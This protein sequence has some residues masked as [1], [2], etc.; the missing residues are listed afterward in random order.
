MQQQRTLVYTL[1]HKNAQLKN[2]TAYPPAAHP[3]Q[4]PA[5]IPRCPPRSTAYRRKKRPETH[6]QSLLSPDQL[7]EYRVRYL[8]LPPGPHQ[9]DK[10]DDLEKRDEREKQQHSIPHVDDSVG[11]TPGSPISAATALHAGISTPVANPGTPSASIGTPTASPATLEARLKYQL[12]DLSHLHWKRRQKRLAEIAREQEML[13]NGEVPEVS[14]IVVEETKPKGEKK[15][16]EKEKEA[17]KKSTS[18]WCV[19]IVA[20]STC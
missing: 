19:Y 15:L 13:A 16:T 12:P 5:A 14:T 9:G 7:E 11:G 2:Y 17:I 10:D 1:R 4:N 18:Y 8:K 20:K 3:I 6:I